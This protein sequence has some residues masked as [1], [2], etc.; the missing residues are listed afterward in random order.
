MNCHNEKKS[1]IEIS[2]YSAGLK[3]L[4]FSKKVFFLKIPLIVHIII[5]LVCE[6]VILYTLTGLDI[7]I[8]NIDGKNLLSKDNIGI[9][10]FVLV[11]WTIGGFYL[12]KYFFWQNFGKEIVILTRKSL[13][14]ETDYFIIK[15]KQEYSII[16]INNFFLN[17]DILVS[18]II[19]KLLDYSA[20]PQGK[21]SFIYNGKK[22][23]ICRGVNESEASVILT[24][25]NTF[26]SS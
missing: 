15:R 19:G 25:L 17:D 3:I 8:G 26:F 4:I 9:V 5:W 21:I 1:N 20:T 6:L 14:V 10:A 2:K 18:P 11:G 13:E 22:I 12:I 16:N 24:E 23:N 7:H